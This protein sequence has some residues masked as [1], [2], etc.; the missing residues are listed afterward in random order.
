MSSYKQNYYK[1]LI[2][3]A[4]CLSRSRKKWPN[5]DIREPGCRAREKLRDKLICSDR[6]QICCRTYL[7]KQNKNPRFGP[8]LPAANVAKET[9]SPRA[10]SATGQQSHSMTTDVRTATSSILCR[11]KWGT[12]CWKRQ[13]RTIGSY[14]S[15][16]QSCDAHGPTFLQF[17][18]HNLQLVP[19]RSLTNNKLKK[20]L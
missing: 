20:S 10:I 18:T 3:T 2:A 15:S 5:A 4:R 16:D 17:P 1:V 11:C 13:I 8:L 9:F 14:A 12:T 6:C 7:T 19:M